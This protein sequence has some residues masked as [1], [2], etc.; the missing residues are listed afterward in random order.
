MYD[1]KM[2]NRQNAPEK[3]DIHPIVNKLKKGDDTQLAHQLGVTQDYISQMR[4]GNR[5]QTERF[6]AA[7][8]E[9]ITQRIEFY[10]SLDEIANQ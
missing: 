5:R 9:L 7:V 4:K 8:A 1:R 3:Y 6:L 2:T 10:K